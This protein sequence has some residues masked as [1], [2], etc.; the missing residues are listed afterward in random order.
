MR[1]EI[2][3][4][5]SE[6]YV[7]SL[8]HPFDFYAGE[9]SVVNFINFQ[10]T[11]PLKAFQH[12]LLSL[13]D[14]HHSPCFHQQFQRNI[15]FFPFHWFAFTH[16]LFRM[17]FWATERKWF[18]DGNLSGN[19]FHIQHQKNWGWFFSLHFFTPTSWKVLHRFLFHKFVVSVTLVA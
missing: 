4:E 7:S 1:C 2:L 5:S 13:L 16:V 12:S 19:S 14:S 10:V 18:T 11:T 9:L 3:H 15:C 6:N 8:K 17:H